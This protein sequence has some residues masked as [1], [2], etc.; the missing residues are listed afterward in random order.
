M[1]IAS[2][3]PNAADQTAPGVSEQVVILTRGELE[4]REKG[5]YIRGV[6][7]ERKDFPVRT[8]AEKE[9]V[10]R[11]ALAV[12]NETDPNYHGPDPNYTVPLSEERS[13]YD[14]RPAG[15]RPPLNQRDQDAR[16]AS[17]DAR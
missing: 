2:S 8:A 4:A 9:R 7:F 16:Q 17:L 12:R 3:G 1:T 5:A 14:P 6:E 10:R 13:P 11:E 15:Q